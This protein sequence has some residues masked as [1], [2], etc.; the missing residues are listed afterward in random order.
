M[1]GCGKYAD[2]TLPPSAGGSDVAITFEEQA[3]P[4]LGRGDARDALNPSV[5]GGREMFYSAWDGRT[6]R[7]VQA[8][9]RDGVWERGDVVLAPDPQTWESSYIAANGSA[10]EVD[11]KIWY[12]YVA[13]PEERPRIGLARAWHKEPLPVLETGPYMAWDEQAVAD[14]YVIR[15]GGEFYMY[16]LGQDR[17]A[18]QRLGL[19]RSPDGVH[20]RKL[21]TNPILELGAPGSFD[22]NGL[23]EPAVWQARGFYWMLYTGR[24]AGE[25]RRMGMA[26]STDGVH[27]TKLAVVFTGAHEWDS[28]VIC[29]PTVE[30][31]DDSTVAVW[32]G[33]GDVARQDYNLNGQIGYGVLRMAAK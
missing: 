14:P 4:V 8:G 16:Y 3:S 10:L 17:A 1:A 11:G 13:G 18:R 15:I 2:F 30:V 9:L 28:K 20:W 26:R 21:R 6:W 33:G 23:G 32:F 31:L 24:G 12:W 29:D 5:V 25:V 7:T 19:A 22:E 27:W